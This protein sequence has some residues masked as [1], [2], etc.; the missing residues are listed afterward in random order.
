M[1][2]IFHPVQNNNF[3]FFSD[4]FEKRVFNFETNLF[5][6]EHVPNVAYLLLDGVI[7]LGKKKRVLKHIEGK[8]LIGLKNL[9]QKTPV[10][11]F[12]SIKPNSAVLIIDRSTLFKIVNKKAE[13]Y[14]FIFH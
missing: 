7:T 9:Y 11:F 2:D 14:N 12:A 8:F 10:K 4:L 13:L 5:Y 3:M 1:K 6:E